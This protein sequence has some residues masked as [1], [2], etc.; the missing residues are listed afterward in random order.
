MACTETAD[1]K[2]SS[3]LHRS[4]KPLLS[5]TFPRMNTSPKISAQIFHHFFRRCVLNSVVGTALSIVPA[6]AFYA[7][8]F[9]YTPRQLAIIAVLGLLD[10]AS[11]LP[12][13]LWILRRLMAPVALALAPNSALEER[14]RG[15]ARLLDSPRLVLIRIFG[16]HAFCATSVLAL[17][18]WAANRHLNLGVPYST[19]P[20]YWLLN[21]TVVPV[22][23]AVYE[24]SAMEREIQEPAA[25]LAC[26]VPPDQP[27]AR[28]FTLADRMRV[29]F[30]LLAVA[31]TLV[32]LASI[33]LREWSALSRVTGLL[34]DL[35][36][37]GFASAALLLFLMRTLGR[38][39]NQQTSLLIAALD[40]LAGGDLQ[41]R[42]QL[43]STSEFGQIASHI[44]NMAIRLTERQ[45]LRDLFGSYM[46]PA[47]A[48]DLLRNPEHTGRTEKRY[49][50]IV[51]IDVRG[52]TA[53]SR[54]R[55]PE[56]VLHALNEL[57]AAMVDGIT[58]Y[59]GT[60]NKY[61]GDG[62]LAIF[63]APVPLDNP[64]LPL[65]KRR[66]KSHDA[67]PKSTINETDAICRS[68]RSA[69]AFMPVRSWSAV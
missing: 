24:F 8:T 27:D 44:N 5:A 68:Y 3:D 62:L 55:P 33:A 49:V 26:S 6:G 38:Q 34:R 4:A 63:G 61:L 9:T 69:S 18:I 32:M 46:S 52:F 40:R 25:V 66:C 11:F 48:E 51:F 1:Y 45:R 20:L 16:P 59:G 30:P 54:T 36:V 39:V 23:H 53:F 43:H 19:F 7:F 13:D 21:L 22:A 10:L 17:L 50:C 15:L 58:H 60:V 28:A 47:V 14:R 65:S 56:V 67:S 2:A 12:I 41:A 31:P 37:V 57:L 35:A 64:C 42:A 29:F